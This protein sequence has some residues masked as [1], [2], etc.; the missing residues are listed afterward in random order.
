MILSVIARM[1]VVCGFFLGITTDPACAGEPIRAHPQNPYILEFR[2]KPTVLRTFAESYSSVIDGSLPFIP[3][4][5]VLKRDGMNLTRVWCIGFPPDSGGAQ[6]FLQPWPRATGQGNALDGLGK[7][8]LS[9]WDEN[10]FTRLKAFAQAASD[11]GIVVEFTMFSVL[12]GQTE[13]EKVPF[14]PSNNVQGYGPNNIYDPFRTVDAN[15]L[16]AQK[17]AV[18]RIVRELN[19]FDN[20][21][22]EIQNEPFWNEPGVK[23]SDEVKFHNEML[24]AIRAEEATLPNRHMVAHNFPQKMGAM[25]SD[26][27]ILN[28]HYPILLTLPTETP[29]QGAELLLENHYSRGRILSLDETDT[30]TT[31]QAR[32]EAWMFLIGGGGI[33]DGLDAYDDVYSPSD[34]EGDTVKGNAMRAGVRNIGIFMDQLH[35]VALRRDRSWVHSGIPSGA[36]LQASSSPNQQ[37]IAYLHHGESGPVDFV[38]H[39]DPISK[40]NHNVSLRVTLQAGTWRAVWTRPSDL[41]ELK[42]QEFVHSGG[43]I[44]LEQ[45]AY[46][47]DVALRIDRTGPEDTTPPPQP[48]DV[49]ATSNANGSIRLSWEDV[50]AFDLANYNIYRASSPGVPMDEAHRIDIL[51]PDATSFTD[52]PGGDGVTYYYVVSPADTGE[53][54]MASAVEVSAISTLQPPKLRI[55]G[56]GL[57]GLVLEWPVNSAGW[58]LQESENLTVGSWGYSERAPE[59]VGD[60]FEVR[61]TPVDPARFFRLIQQAP[62]TPQLRLFRNGE[63][64]IVLEWNMAAEGWILQESLD[65]SPGSW[66]KITAVPILVGG[67]YQVQIFRSLPRCF[68]RM[69]SP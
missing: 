22:F 20:V 66:K 62:P 21:Y 17:L 13:W 19:E 2:G 67:R 39:Y 36:N 15:L 65:L 63:G 49:G 64:L 31:D 23:D 45:V 69:A 51:P 53:N 27:D 12:Y 18:R 9:A 34:P 68:F 32:L 4:L 5:D 44:T 42:V 25:S 7:W 29:I 30:K 48:G 10:Y 26:F 55:S 1:T 61:F 28:E 58:Y 47:E 50:P 8:D 46:N 11:R 14:H 6:N 24:E 33:Y 56:D 57:G 52:Q 54:E 3:Y 40:S 35:L 41:T 60:Q 38:L 59:E 37:Y 16:A 43:N